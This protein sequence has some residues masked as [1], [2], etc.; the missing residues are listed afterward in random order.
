MIIGLAACRVYVTLASRDT[1]LSPHKRHTSAG[2]LECTKP[3]STT[4]RPT[5][6]P[7]TRPICSIPIPHSL[8]IDCSAFAQRIG[9]LDCGYRLL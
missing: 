1:L 4:L 6:G 3:N 5:A 2:P 9:P 8:R 7:A